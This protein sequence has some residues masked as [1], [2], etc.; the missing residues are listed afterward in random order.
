MMFKASLRG[1]EFFSEVWATVELQKFEL[2]A[3]LSWC[4]EVLSLSRCSSSGSTQSS[5]V[6]NLLSILLRVLRMK[7]SHKV[8]VE[9]SIYDSFYFTTSWDSLGQIWRRG[10]FMSNLHSEENRTR[11]MTVCRLEGCSSWAK[12][13]ILVH[14]ELSF[15][16]TEVW[17]S[18]GF[19]A[20]N[21]RDAA[22][23]GMDSRRLFA[24]SFLPSFFIDLTSVLVWIQANPD[25]D[26]FSTFYLLLLRVQM[27]CMQLFNLFALFLLRDPTC[28]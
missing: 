18:S 3:N 5:E 7:S 19:R 21:R 12:A 9:S 24:F 20:R 8:G 23:V 4:H 2:Q 15:S 16:K 27:Q 28:C 25:H 26:C 17:G 1:S 11:K 22:G 10:E 13:V 14:N 6:T